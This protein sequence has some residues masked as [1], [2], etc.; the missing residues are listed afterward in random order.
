MESIISRLATSENFLACLCS[1]VGWS[2]SNFVGNPEDRFSWV[3]AHIWNGT[4]D[5]EITYV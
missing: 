3:E 2:E 1:L 5:L 4:F